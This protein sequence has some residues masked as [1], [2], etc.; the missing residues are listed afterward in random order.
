[1]PGARR[2]LTIPRYLLVRDTP[3]EDLIKSA[4]RLLRVRDETPIDWFS[5]IGLLRSGE[6]FFPN[7]RADFRA[8]TARTSDELYGYTLIFAFTQPSISRMANRLKTICSLEN[9]KTDMRGLNA[10]SEHTE[11]DIRA[12]LNTLQFL[13]RKGTPLSEVRRVPT[14]HTIH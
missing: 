7:T 1:M 4:A 10:L 14:P 13:K 12:C 2:D 11:C 6:G 8:N 3:E 9:Y 5:F